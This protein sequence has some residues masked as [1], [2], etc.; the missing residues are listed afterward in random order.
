MG[1]SAAQIIESKATKREKCRSLMLR[2][3]DKEKSVLLAKAHEK[4]REW[5]TGY[6]FP[7]PLFDG[8]Y[9]ATSRIKGFKNYNSIGPFRRE[10]LSD[11]KNKHLAS[12]L[13]KNRLSCLPNTKP[14]PMVVITAFLSFISGGVLKLPISRK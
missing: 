4:F 10:T 8:C 5:M 14:Y 1:T 12:H 7:F 2:V 3:V 6:A 11:A 13:A 9:P